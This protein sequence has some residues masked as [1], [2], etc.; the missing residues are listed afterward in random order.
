MQEFGKVPLI[1]AGMLGESERPPKYFPAK[2]F[3]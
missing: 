3:M 1:D 2:V